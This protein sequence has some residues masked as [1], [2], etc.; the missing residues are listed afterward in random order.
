M[1]FMVLYYRLPG[2]IASLALTTYISTL[3]MI[4]KLGP[5]IGPI[6]ITLAGIA[7]FVL[8]VGMAVDANILVF[9]RMKEELRHGRALPQAIEHGF[10]RAWSSIR[11]SNVST[12]ITCGILW[13]FGDQF[14]A[15]LVQGFA[16]T[17]GLGV[18]ISMF[19]AIVVT[20]TFLR[21]LVGSPLANNMWLF[22]PDLKL[23]PM[24]GIRGATPFVFD[25][26]RRRG[27]YFLLSAAL[28]VPGIVSL[29]IAPALKPGIEFSSGATF[30]FAFDNVN[31]SQDELRSALSHL[32]HSEARVQKT[33]D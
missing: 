7:G 2:V 20:R 10:D 24:R 12:L 33:S 6:T 23:D 19:S 4:F 32:G 17:L 8:S 1:V 29:A 26:V 5:I 13:W 15:S 16:L 3:M 14:G 22:A 9:E 25:F 30:T 31:V 18:L 11:D 21:L 27:F 28:L